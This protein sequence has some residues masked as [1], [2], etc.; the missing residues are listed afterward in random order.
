MRSYYSKGTICVRGDF[1][2]IY[3]L[4]TLEYTLNEDETFCYV[5]TPNYSVIDLLDCRYFQG[6]PGLN[7]DLRREKYI[8]DNYLPTFIEERVPQK[9]RE[10]YYELL[11]LVNMDFMDPIEWLIRT[12]LQYFGDNFFMMRYEEKKTISIKDFSIHKTN[13]ELSKNIL[14][15]IA[16][17]NDVIINEDKID[18][19]NRKVFHELLMLFYSRSYEVNKNK[20]QE[21]IEKAKRNGKY[22][23]RKPIDYDEELFKD[24][25]IKIE[26][27]EMKPTEA[28]NILGI[29]ID[30]Y[31][32]ERKK[33][34]NRQL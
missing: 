32:R 17:G 18:D 6:I 15:E 3:R 27:K 14:E 12:P 2:I 23:G 28:I 24:F 10:D 1:D 22:K 33:L 19:S 7:L 21:G 13:S 20:K 29:S 4:C 26:N 30:K 5:F 25:L 31:Y 34:L 11:D 9:N 8:R 16:Y